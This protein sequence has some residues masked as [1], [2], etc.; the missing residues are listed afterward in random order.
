MLAPDNS[1]LHEKNP[2]L[3]TS[4]EVEGVVAYLKANGESVTSQPVNK[5]A[6]YLG[7]LASEHVQD[8]ILTGNAESARRQIEAACIQ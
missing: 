2:N 7:F 3:H 1:L 5:L 6:A 4:I 8:G